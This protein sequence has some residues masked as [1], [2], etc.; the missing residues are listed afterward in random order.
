MMP[1][2]EPYLEYSEHSCR[3]AL[4]PLSNHADFNGTLAYVEAVKPSRVLTDGS[5]SP[6]AGALA[7]EITG[8]LGIPAQPIWPLTDRDWT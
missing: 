2:D 3:I 1:P 5:R 7:L 4:S 8:R 6:H